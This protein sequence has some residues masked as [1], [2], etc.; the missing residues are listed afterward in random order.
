MNPRIE[1]IVA[2]IHT[3]MHTWELKSKIECMRVRSLI[4]FFE[5]VKPTER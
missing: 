1:N 4:A 3:S 5:Q 2:L